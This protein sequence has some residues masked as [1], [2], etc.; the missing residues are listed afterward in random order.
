MNKRGHNS[1]IISVFPQPRMQYGYASH[2]RLIPGKKFK[3]QIHFSSVFFV[4][5]NK[6]NFDLKNKIQNSPLLKLHTKLFVKKKKNYTP[7]YF[8]CDKI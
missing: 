2:I 1:K 4:F 7:N 3:K 5:S 8:L 6:K